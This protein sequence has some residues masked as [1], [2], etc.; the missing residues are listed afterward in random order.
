MA[1]LGPFFLSRKVSRQT[2][3][4]ALKEFGKPSGFMK[5]SADARTGLVSRHAVLAYS[6]HKG[7]DMTMKRCAIQC[8]AAVFPRQF[9]Q[10][11]SRIARGSTALVMARARP[12]V[13][14]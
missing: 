1:G 11:G 13:F 5:S 14:T 10:L 12:L 6:S 4:S 2:L 3:V 7:G 8:P 9:L